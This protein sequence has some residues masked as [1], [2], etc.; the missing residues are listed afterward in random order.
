MRLFLP[1][2]PDLDDAVRALDLGERDVG[3]AEAVAGR[4]HA[5]ARAGAPPDGVDPR[6]MPV[7]QVVVGELG[8]VGDVLQVV[9]YLLARSGDDDRDG[10]GVHGER[11]SISLA[12]ASRARRRRL[13]GSARRRER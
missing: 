1:V 9:E 11:K 3:P 5:E 12:P 6:Q 2:R 13:L 10:H 8:V 4:L 7:D